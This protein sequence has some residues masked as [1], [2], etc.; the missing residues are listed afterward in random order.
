MS[1]IKEADEKLEDFYTYRTP[2]FPKGTGW[3]VK[4]PAVSASAADRLSYQA[5]CC[6]PLVQYKA[7]ATT[8]HYARRAPY[9]ASSDRAAVY[10]EPGTEFQLLRHYA[11]CEVEQVKKLLK[12]H[13]LLTLD[14]VVKNYCPPHP[15]GNQVRLYFDGGHLGTMTTGGDPTYCAYTFKQADEGPDCDCMC[16]EYFEDTSEAEERDYN[17]ERDCYC[18]TYL[19]EPWWDGSIDTYGSTGMACKWRGNLDN[20]EDVVGKWGVLDIMDNWFKADKEWYLEDPSYY[21]ELLEYTNGIST[22][23]EMLDSQKTIRSIVE[24][25]MKH[26]FK[27]ACRQ[28]LAKFKD[29]LL[30]VTWSFDHAKHWCFYGDETLFFDEG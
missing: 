29:E 8:G 27:E 20:E 21:T 14:A 22:F 17:E 26:P 5:A 24:D 18:P 30:Q 13:P 7:S 23:D 12:N 10:W 4:K 1:Q 6:C 19:N 16:E 9:A 25:R 15:N 3:C 2:H 11:N 28:Q